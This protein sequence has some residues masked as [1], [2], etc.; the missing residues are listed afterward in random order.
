MAFGGH[1]EYFISKKS[2]VHSY[3]W[4]PKSVQIS[5]SYHWCKWAKFKKNLDKMHKMASD[6]HVR[7]QI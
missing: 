2:D 4:G 5:A 1:I 6:G 7:F 3:E